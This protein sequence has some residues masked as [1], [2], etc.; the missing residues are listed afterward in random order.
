MRML[1]IASEADPIG[2]V[3]VNGKPLDSSG[4]AR[5]TGATE[6][7][8]ASLTDELERN[9]VFSR[10]RSGRIYSR[11][12]VREVRRSATNKK[13]GKLGGNPKLCNV[14]G[15]PRSDNQPVMLSLKTQ[16]PEAREERGSS[17]LSIDNPSEC[18]KRRKRVSYPQDFE[19]FWK[20]YPTDQNMA[21]T[22]AGKQW[23]RL[24]DPDRKAA[25]DSIPGFLAYCRANPTYRAVHAERYLK[26][27]RFEGHLAAASK[28]KSAAV[29]S[30]GTAQWEAWLAYRRREG[31]GTAFIESEGRTHGQFTFP[32]EWPPKASPELLANLEDRACGEQ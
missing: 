7:E 20:A 15:I 30:V 14:T 22:E 13:N 19:E 5:L 4:V 24:S 25:I 18:P 32:S 12:M 21:K 1:C 8:A 3:V 9:G 26:E 6:Q 31:L 27:R 16:I 11:R 2:H 17:G 10:D 28:M 29:V 23:S